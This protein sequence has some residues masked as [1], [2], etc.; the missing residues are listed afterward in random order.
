MYSYKKSFISETKHKLILML[1][2]SKD[3]TSTTKC[4]FVT[5]YLKDGKVSFDTHSIFRLE[6][7][8]FYFSFREMPKMFIFKGCLPFLTK[9][10]YLRSPFDLRTTFSRKV[11]CGTTSPRRPAGIVSSLKIQR[12]SKWEMIYAEEY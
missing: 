10:Q 4:V 11:F 8:Y 2:L 1:S 12:Y 6:S 5:K 9:Q 3:K 7:R